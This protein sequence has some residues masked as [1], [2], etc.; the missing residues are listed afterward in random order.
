MLNSLGIQRR[1]KTTSP[2]SKMEARLLEIRH[3]PGAL[4]L[5]F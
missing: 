2:R 4:D 5:P 1:A 3:I